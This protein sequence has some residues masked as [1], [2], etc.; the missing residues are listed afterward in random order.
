MRDQ[1]KT[2]KDN[3]QFENQT[4]NAASISEVMERVNQNMTATQST[5]T[6]SPTVQAP[7]IP[8]PPKPQPAPV[9]KPEPEAKKDDVFND[10]QQMIEKLNSENE[11]LQKEIDKLKTDLSQ[12]AQSS[13]EANKKE[14]ITR[15]EQQKQKNS[16]DYSTLVKQIH[17]LRTR[18]TQKEKPQQEE[19]APKKPEPTLANI[20]PLTSVPNVITGI[21][22][23]ESGKTLEGVLL[24]IKNDKG[25]PVRAIKTNMIGQFVLSTPVLNGIYTIEVNSGKIEGQS[26]GIISVE[27]KGEVLPPVEIRGR[28]E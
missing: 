7:Q 9:I 28:K 14:I 1:F 21:V 23:D 13:D 20:Q 22:V 26:F 16:A 8:T 24:I 27:T 10:A 18:L 12:Q 6:I 19:Q 2:S 25:D 17:D 15:L 4:Q 5:L 3:N 11:K